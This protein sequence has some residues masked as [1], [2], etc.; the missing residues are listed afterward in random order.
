MS[1]D[2]D[3]LLA[4]AK[5]LQCTLTGDLFSAA[6]IVMLCAWRDGVAVPCDPQTLVAQA[7]CIRNCIPLGM[8]GAVKTSILCDIAAGI[9]PPPVTGDFRITQLSDIRI[10]QAGDSRIIS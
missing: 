7:T 4:R 1:C 2:L 5:C 3:Q 8:M 10:T 6:E 9:V